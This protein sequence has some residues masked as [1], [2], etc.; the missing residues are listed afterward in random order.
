MNTM[1]NTP[2]PSSQSSGHGH[3]PPLC[4]RDIGWCPQAAAG[5]KHPVRP[6]V[7]AASRSEMDRL[8]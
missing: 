8:I 7:I 6:P 1:I 5:D 4:D 2:A 3:A